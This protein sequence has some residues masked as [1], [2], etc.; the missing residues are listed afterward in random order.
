MTVTL[1]SDDL[2]VWSVRAGAWAAVHGT[3]TVMVGASA[4]DADIFLTGSVVV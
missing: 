4:D 1:A 3:F 2:S